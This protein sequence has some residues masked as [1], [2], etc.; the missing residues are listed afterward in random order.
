MT[1]KGNRQETDPP[2]NSN[3][4]TGNV[5]NLKLCTEAGVV[6]DPVEVTPIEKLPF[7]GKLTGR[8]KSSIV[9]RIL[10]LLVFWGLFIYALAIAGIWWGSS[11]IIE[12]SFK[13][14]AVEWVGKLDELGTPLYASEDKRLFKSI[15]DHVARFPELAYLRYYDVDN[16][17]VIAEYTSKQFLD[18][19][20]PYL[21]NEHF[22][23]L[24]QSAKSDDTV[25]VNTFEGGLSLVRAAAPILIRSIRSDGFMEFNLENTEGGAEQQKVVGFI[26]LGLD[27]GAHR[28][29]LLKNILRGSLLIAAIFLIAIIIGRSIIKKSLSPLSSLREPLKKLAAGDID[30]RVQG[31]GDQEIDAIANALNTT[32]A[33]LKD[34]DQKLQKLANCDALTGLLNKQSFQLQ[35]EKELKRVADEGDSS[36]LI[37]IDLDKFK[38]INDSLGHAAG[39]RLLAQVAEILLNRTRETDVLARFGGDE[40]TVIV[41]SVS[42]AQAE[43]IAESIVNG[44]QEF[45]FVENGKPFNICCSLG[46][47]MI[48]SGESS[49]EE[50]FAKADLACFQAKSN[51]RNCYHFYDDVTLTQAGKEV[52]ISWSKTIGEALEGDLFLLKFQPIVG[53]A[54]SSYDFY[55]AQLQ[56]ELQNGDIADSSVFLPAAERLG[57][58]EKI[59]DWLLHN[60]F[61]KLESISV[62]GRNVKLLISL[63]SQHF[64][65][66]DFVQSVSTALEV[67]Q[68]ES[69]SVVFQITEQTAIKQIERTKQRM[70]ALI[71]IGFRF[72]LS[73]VGTG[74]S[75]FG[76]LKGIPVD[77][78]KIDGNC[79]SSAKADPIDRVMVE[80]IIKIAR[81]LGKQTIGEFVRDAKTITALRGQGVDFAQG[82]F[83]S[84]PMA[85][86]HA[87]SYQKLVSKIS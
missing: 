69:S 54:D 16:N 41:R 65:M 52:E 8:K 18:A 70:L 59:G 26:E 78:L 43:S 6:G 80:A 79:F 21:S 10:W 28:E 63:S 19:F 36:A 37:F 67:Y 30:V 14:Q 48:D 33:A 49:V 40:F 45:V 68:V 83:L 60:A 29:Q 86:L 9:D 27:F 72:S 85:T 34:R 22:S 82:S 39:D 5:G 2:G 47:T 84:K 7:S 51:G 32:I 20:I 11:Y 62:G 13:N 17:R 71:G 87:K 31:A 42:E 76:Y 4:V 55:E 25:I 73:H 24:R 15:Q 57:L 81:A 35:L 56:L 44:M 61:K 38:Y 75:S 23:V 58:S 50:T 64:E 77:Y 12:D 1:S 74:S 53:L 3:K 66:S 46:A